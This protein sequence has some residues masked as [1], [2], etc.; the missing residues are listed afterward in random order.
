M[1]KSEPNGTAMQL[2]ELKCCVIMPTYNNAGTLASVVS[3]V[4][5]YCEDLIVINDGSTDGTSEILK[6]FSSRI[7][8]LTHPFNWG[9]GTALRNG[10]EYA[11]QEGFSYAISIDSDGQH[12]PSDIQ[13]F[14]L[15]ASDF[16]DTLLV[17]AR[18]LRADGMPGKNTFANRFSN[19]WFKVETGI[20]LEDTQSGF[21]LYPLE[22]IDL[23]SSHFTGGYEFELEI[24][25]FSA[26]KGVPVRNIPVNVYYPPEGERVS[27]FKPFRD[28]SR[29]SVLNTVLVFYCLFWK[30]PADFF[31][32]LS[33]C[34]VKSFIDSYVIH[35][36]ESNARIACAV[37]LGVF[38]GIV[39]IWGYQ[40][41]CALALAHLLRLN[42]VIVVVASN[43]SL[44]PV[45]PFI[46]FGSYWTGCRILG[47]PLLFA[48]GEFSLA[49][50]GQVLVQYV[51]GSFVLAASAALAA[52]IVSIFVLSL[53][54]HRSK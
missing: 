19:F 2:K 20:R 52:G 7:K 21:R 5:E 50:T 6:S 12:F 30:W 25:V 43:I 42:K 14:A 38:M 39:P 34:N 46:L 26:W 22:K 54:R 36:P 13:A 28:F 4:L 44:P 23:D 37:M 51:L 1:Q 40:M 53:V 49:D 10:L 35:S 18:N 9:K 11:R 29:I 47:K 3:G 33:W 32:K 45:I 17:G 27:H 16:P 15:A 48:P 24:L 8:V 41:I 31:R